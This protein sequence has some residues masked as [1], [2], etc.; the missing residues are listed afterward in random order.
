MI[1]LKS[2]NNITGLKVWLDASDADTINDG[3][4][5]SNGS[6]VQKWVDKVGGYVFRSGTGT[7]GNSYN[8]LT[9]NGIF[10]VRGPSYS[11]GVVNG[12]NA[13]TFNYYTGGGVGSGAGTANTE[14]N[15]SFRRL[16]CGS[17]TPI[18]SA[19]YS[20][21]VVFLPKENREQKSQTGTGG[22]AQSQYIMT[23]MDASRSNAA[24]TGPLSGYPGPGSS[25]NPAGYCE[26]MLY[27][28]STSSV[29]GNA[30]RNGTIAYTNGSNETIIINS[31]QPSIGTYLSNQTQEPSGLYETSGKN[32]QYGKVNVFGIRHSNSIKRFSVVRDGYTRKDNFVPP[33]IVSGALN[34]A[35][36]PWAGRDRRISPSPR[37]ANPIVTIGAVA[38]GYDLGKTSTRGTDDDGTGIR[39]NQS[40]FEGYF[41]ELL[42]WDRILTE[43][44]SNS[45]E[46]YLR[47]KWIG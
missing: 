28:T 42:F 38:P 33:T 4:D 8:T 9:S 17:I 10:K 41:C 47:K 20:M 36:N 44:E 29:A 12:K 18:G 27:M 46:L 7:L 21:Y 11:V 2:P 13:I 31:V 6:T 24:G 34:T 23:V 15:I 43:S 25:A 14:D 37:I 35:N 3:R 45:V 16:A 39:T 40:P 30:Y 26:R 22:A 1:G 19:T 5:I 32:Y